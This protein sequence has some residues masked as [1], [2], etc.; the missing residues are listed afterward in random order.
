MG[1]GELSG[2]PDKNAGGY[3]RWTNII[4]GSSDTPS[5]FVSWK[6]KFVGARATSPRA[7][8]KFPYFDEGGQKPLKI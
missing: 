2:K 8:T 6:P 1:T 7:P 5:C 4:Q 3:L